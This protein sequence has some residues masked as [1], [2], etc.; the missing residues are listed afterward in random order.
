MRLRPGVLLATVV[1]A[2]LLPPVTMA[3][4]EARCEY[5]G[6]SDT[7]AGTGWYWRFPVGTKL[8]GSKRGGLTGAARPD[9]L[10]VVAEIQRD[11]AFNPVTQQSSKERYCWFR[12][13]LTIRSADGV[14]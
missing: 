8:T 5:R 14:V 9:E 7:S 4:E 12:T 11:S 13:R 6:P 2:S 1:L 10:Q 3:S